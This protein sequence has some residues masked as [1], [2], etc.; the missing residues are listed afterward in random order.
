VGN[1][2]ADPRFVAESD[3]HLRHDSPCRN[4]GSNQ[5]PGLTQTDFEGDPR[6]ADGN[7]D[8]GADEF[9]P[10]LYHIGDGRAG[11]GHEPHL[12]GNPSTSAFWAVSMSVLDPPW[13][14]PGLDGQLY[15]EPSRLAIIPLGRFSTTGHLSFSFVIP[16]T[17]PEMKVPTQ[18]LM[19]TH[20][21]NL[22]EVMVYQ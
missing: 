11:W 12:I 4:K 3:Y 19:G 7:V 22:N 2:D 15:L 18:A 1:I 20:L 9:F 13:S 16:K 5:A 6:V 21:S 14:V 17:F 8:I 10:H